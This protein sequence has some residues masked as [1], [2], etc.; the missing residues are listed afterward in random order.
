VIGAQACWDRVRSRPGSRG[1]V[2]VGPLGAKVILLAGL[3][4]TLPVAADSFSD[5][6]DD[7][8]PDLGNAGE[9]LETTGSREAPEF[10]V[11]RF[12]LAPR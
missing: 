1:A 5:G 9:Q 11:A 3:R 12:L 10:P 7:G 4:P 2:K 6:R 8:A